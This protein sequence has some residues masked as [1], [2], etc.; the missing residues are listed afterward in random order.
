MACRHCI[1]I[2]PADAVNFFL[3]R[4]APD[5]GIP[6]AGLASNGALQG[7]A[8]SGKGDPVEPLPDP[9]S[10]SKKPSMVFSTPQFQKKTFSNRSDYHR[11]QAAEKRRSSTGC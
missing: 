5:Q 11:T 8:C 6:L 4:P 7:T 2:R 9:G 1:E 3:H 10:L